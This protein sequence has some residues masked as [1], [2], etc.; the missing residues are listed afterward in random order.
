MPETTEDH[1]PSILTERDLADAMYKFIREGHDARLTGAL[2]RHP[3]GT[4]AHMLHVVGWTAEDLR[5]ALM[6]AD[7][8]YC[9]GQ[10]CHENPEWGAI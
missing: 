8:R 3:A 10:A 1:S 4:V 7:A 2:V 5:L 9:L 6:R